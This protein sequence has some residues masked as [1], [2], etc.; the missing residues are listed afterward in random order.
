MNTAYH[1]FP[2]LAALIFSACA[3]SSPNTVRQTES[4]DVCMQYDWDKVQQLVQPYLSDVLYTSL[5]MQGQSSE[6]RPSAAVTHVL[7][8]QVPLPEEVHNLLLTLK[9]SDC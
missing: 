4:T 2:I 6:Y 1:L 3:S 5:V 7:G 9:K 8:M